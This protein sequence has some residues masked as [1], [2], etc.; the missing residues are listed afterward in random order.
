[1]VQERYLVEVERTTN[2]WIVRE[3][4][5]KPQYRTEPNNNGCWPMSYIAGYEKEVTTRVYGKE[6]YHE[7]LQ[8]LV[9]RTAFGNAPEVVLK[10]E[11]PKTEKGILHS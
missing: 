5:E 11:E 10:E 4:E 6:Q 8:Y 1:M 2:G 3:I 7:M 9:D